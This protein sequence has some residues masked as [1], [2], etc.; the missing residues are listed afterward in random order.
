MGEGEVKIITM[1][2]Y[3]RDNFFYFNIPLKLNYEHFFFANKTPTRRRMFE[4]IEELNKFEQQGK[5]INI[6]IWDKV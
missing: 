6:S 2:S 1:D 5:V 3:I 4:T